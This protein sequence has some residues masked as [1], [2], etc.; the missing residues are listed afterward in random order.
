MATGSSARRVLGTYPLSLKVWSGQYTLLAPP[1]L[2]PT[3][4]GA[5]PGTDP[6]G[7]VL[8]FLDH[9]VKLL[10]GHKPRP[11][12]LCEKAQKIPKR[13]H[14]V[15]KNDSQTEGPGRWSTPLEFPSHPMTPR[16]ASL[17]FSLLLILPLTSVG[18]ASTLS[19]DQPPAQDIHRNRPTTPLSA[20]KS[21]TQ[22]P[23][24]GQ[25]W[26]SPFLALSTNSSRVHTVDTLVSL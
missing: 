19:V 6:G 18:R 13:A 15:M 17:P 20:K 9:C 7:L 16:L 11:R 21:N 5:L 4:Y 3:S 24:T 22:S 23:Q 25:L 12:I 10:K 8:Y 1:W 2:V 14:N 26:E